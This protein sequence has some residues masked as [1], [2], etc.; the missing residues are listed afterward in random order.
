MLNSP[1]FNPSE[2]TELKQGLIET[3]WTNVGYVERYF[4]K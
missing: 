3:G 2:K 4:I 1:H